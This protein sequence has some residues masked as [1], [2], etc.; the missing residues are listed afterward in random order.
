[1]AVYRHLR[2]LS[3]CS[4][5]VCTPCVGYRACRARRIGTDCTD[6]SG[7]QTGRLAR[8]YNAEDKDF[9]GLACPSSLWARRSDRAVCLQLRAKSTVSRQ[10]RK[11]PAQNQRCRSIWSSQ[12]RGGS[13]SPLLCCHSFSAAD[14]F[15]A[16]KPSPA[17]C[18]LSEGRFG[19][20]DLR[21]E[22]TVKNSIYKKRLKCFVLNASLS[23]WKRSR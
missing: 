22:K 18:C 6:T 20:S 3:T 8:W 10:G 5:R 13:G 14:F 21:Q 7:Q 1:M 4:G 2:R 11:R 17:H 12:N 23:L 16:H 9:T 19:F 15:S